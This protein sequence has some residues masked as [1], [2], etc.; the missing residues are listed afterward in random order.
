MCTYIHTYICMHTHIRFVTTCTMH[1][2]IR[3]KKY[4]STY[5]YIALS[6]MLSIL[7]FSLLPL[8]SYR[9]APRMHFHRHVS[10]NN[11][12]YASRELDCTR[13]LTKIF[14]TKSL[15]T[16]QLYFLRC[17]NILLRIVIDVGLK[18]LSA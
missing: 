6:S 11:I 4:T 15:L 18:N 2:H 16:N 12:S 9:G 1:H 8:Y 3:T 7:L 5:K 13:M 10:S 17:N 14:L